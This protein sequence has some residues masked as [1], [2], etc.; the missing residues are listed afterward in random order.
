MQDTLVTVAVAVAVTVALPEL[1]RAVATFVVRAE[2]L[3]VAVHVVLVPGDTG[4]HE[5][6]VKSSVVST[7]VPLSS[8]SV[9]DALKKSP[10]FVIL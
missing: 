7:G 9:P 5:Q 4:P 10:V 2:R 8:R 3:R 6:T 1:P